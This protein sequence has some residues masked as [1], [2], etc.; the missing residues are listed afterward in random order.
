MRTLLKNGRILDPS[1]GMDAI[2]SV[3]IED[4][5]IVGRAKLP[6]QRDP[7]SVA[8]QDDDLLGAETLGGDHP[9]QAHGAV[10]DDMARLR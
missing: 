6:R 4:D 8:A 5:Q 10:T 3:L 7:V 1:Q 2:G 9:A